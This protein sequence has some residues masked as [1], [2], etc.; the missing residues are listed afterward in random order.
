MNGNSVELARLDGARVR[1][2]TRHIRRLTD[3]IGGTVLWPGDPGWVDS[4]AV[5]NGG[6]VRIPGLVVRPASASDVAAVVDL[7]RRYGLLV[8]VKGGGHNLAGTAIAE[9]AVMLDMSGMSDVIVDP[10]GRSVQV[11]PGCLLAD[12]D[13][14]TQQHGLATV[15]GLVSRT[16][17]AGLTLGG[18]FGYLTRRFGWTVDN[19]LEVEVVTADGMV[20]TAD[21]IREPALFWAVRG[22][23]GNFGV[24]TRFTFALHQVGPTVTGGLTAWGGD[25]VG[26]VLAAYRAITESAPRELTAAAFVSLTPGDPAIPPEQHGRPMVGIFLCH[27]GNV[28]GDLD[29]LGRLGRPFLELVGERP[30]VEQQAMFDADLPA[31]LAYHERSEFLPGLSGKFLDVF[32]HH[33]LRVPSAVGESVLLHLGGALNEHAEDDGA[34]GNRDAQ[35]VTW[36]AATRPGG[37]AAVDVNWVDQAW[38]ATWPFSTGG[39]YVNFQGRDD[40]SARIQETYRTTYERLVAVKRDYDPDNLFRVNRNIHP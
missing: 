20:R 32:H 11:G 24:I 13:H 33:A 15:L 21:R 23:G 26:D 39:N 37:P 40:G 1:L 19:L 4:V 35:Y 6:V 3:S 36:C 18:G 10:V 8:T 27:S 5:W 2:E 30:Y 16:G 17:V 25:R 28:G 22:G 31:G 34:V 29:P 14:P 7:A 12:V 9:R 38:A